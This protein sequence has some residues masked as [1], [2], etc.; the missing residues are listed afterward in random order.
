MKRSDYL[1]LALIVFGFA[2]GAYYYGDLPDPM[3]THYGPDGQPD[4]FTA[5]PWGAFILPAISV[6]LWAIMKVLPAISPKEFSMHR[7]AGAFE[8][9][10]VA[11]IGFMTLLQFAMLR[12]AIEPEFNVRLWVQMVVGGIL[13]V[14]ANYITKT[15]PN[16][17]FGIRTP[18]TLANEEVWFRTHRQ[19]A[20]WFAGLGI[21]ALASAPFPSGLYLTIV[22][23]IG[24]AI[25]LVAYSYIIYVRLDRENPTQASLKTKR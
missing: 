6:G 2:L 14:I 5:L 11:V 16:F 19:A 15:Q 21:L 25:W 23:T 1:A 12:T 8:T 22:A 3:P 10:I 18:W 7:F 20:W 9:V 17:F 13:L 4:G 24:A